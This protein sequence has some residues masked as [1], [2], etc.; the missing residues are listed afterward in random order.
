MSNDTANWV[1]TLGPIVTALVAIAVSWGAQGARISALEAQVKEQA[2]AVQG[3]SRTLQTV[4]TYERRLEI[5]E[6]STADIATMRES[7][8]RMETTLDFLSKSTADLASELR[9]L[10]QQQGKQ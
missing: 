4:L 2:V 1:K 3:N 5:V 10:R 8:V 6:R 7:L 9:A